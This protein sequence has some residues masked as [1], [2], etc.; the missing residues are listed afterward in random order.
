MSQPNAAGHTGDPHVRFYSF[1]AG[2]PMPRPPANFELHPA[3]DPLCR[4]H[5]EALTMGLEMPSPLDWAL[6]RTAEGMRVGWIRPDGA[7]DWQTPDELGNVYHPEGPA[8][9]DGLPVDDTRARKIIVPGRGLQW[10]NVKDSRPGFIEVIS[11]WMFAPVTPGWGL[12]V[13]WPSGTPMPDG[14]AEVPHAYFQPWYTAPFPTVFHIDQVGAVVQFH[15]GDPMAALVPLHDSAREGSRVDGRTESGGV[16]EWPP[17]LRER[18]AA[19]ADRVYSRP[20]GY[21][22]VAHRTDKTGRCPL[23]HATPLVLPGLPTLSPKRQLAAHLDELGIAYIYTPGRY[24]RPSEGGGRVHQPFDDADT[25]LLLTLGDASTDVTALLIEAGVAAVRES[26]GVRLPVGAAEDNARAVT[27][28]AAAGDRVPRG[29][30]ALGL[31]TIIAA[32]RTHD[33]ALPERRVG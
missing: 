24:V 13:G 6:T 28:L 21:S 9:L 16:D 32:R 22:A 3:A 27:A 2:A 14:L 18:V 1:R 25:Y 29:R 5:I 11:G 4:P 10:A 17:A 33:Q 12:R 20:G 30:S 19:V 7:I 8:I 15:R 23:G 26:G 31:A